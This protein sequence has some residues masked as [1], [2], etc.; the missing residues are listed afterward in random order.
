MKG[1]RVPSLIEG[2]GVATDDIKFRKSERK[3]GAAHT[4][5]ECIICTM[6]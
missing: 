3:M 6:W 1:E 5:I 2:S 4:R